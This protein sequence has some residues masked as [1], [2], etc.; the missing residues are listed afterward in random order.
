MV[1]DAVAAGHVA[2]APSPADARRADLRVTP[3]GAELLAGARAWQERAFAG[4]VAGWPAADAARLAAY[5]RR[6][7]DEAPAAASTD[8][9]DQGGS[10]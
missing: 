8:T 2:K 6:L 9:P 5:L 10:P 1:A 3:A 7:A 4:L